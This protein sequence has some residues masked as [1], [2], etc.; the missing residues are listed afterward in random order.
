MPLNTNTKVK[1][2][3]SYQLFGGPVNQWMISGIKTKINIVFDTGVKRKDSKMV[4]YCSKESWSKV[5]SKKNCPYFE[6][7][8]QP[9]KNAF[10]T[11]ISLHK[12]VPKM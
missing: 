1:R 8:G 12:K 4:F 5:F 7:S 2:F 6:N 9:N 3:I 11:N 10:L